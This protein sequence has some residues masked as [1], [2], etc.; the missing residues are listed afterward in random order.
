MN[1]KRNPA[2]PRLKSARDY[3]LYGVDG[4]RYIDLYQNGGYA[5]TGHRPAEVL[6]AL[7]SSAARGLWAEYPSGWQYRVEQM[8]KQLLPFVERVF[9]FPN[10][11]AALKEISACYRAPVKIRETP[12]GFWADDEVNEENEKNAMTEGA[13]PITRW[14]PFGLGPAEEEALAA[15]EMG[16]LFIPLVPFPG[17]FLPVP[18]CRVKGPGLKECGFSPSIEQEIS[19]VL[20]SLM[21]KSIAQ[22]RKLIAECEPDRWREF[23]V[24][25]VKRSGPYLRFEGEE[26]RYAELYRQMLEEGVL[27]PPDRNIPAIIPPVYTPG[28]IKPLMDELRRSYGDS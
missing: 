13:I 7:K 22:T 2:L 20:C 25:G 12:A 6:Q 28:E 10:E 4:R 11:E 1:G 5:M 18:V 8:L 24:P 19:P 21:V 23:D 14:R 3:R 17:R 16:E 26:K 15:G 27:L 9:L